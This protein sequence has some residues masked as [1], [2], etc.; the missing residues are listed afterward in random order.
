MNKEPEF[1]IGWQ[2]MAPAAT[3]RLIKWFCLGLFILAASMGTLLALSQ[4][5]IGI[6]V[7]EWGKLK[8]FHGIMV[9]KPYPHLLS[10]NNLQFYYLVKPDK[11]GFDSDIASKYDGQQVCLLGTLIYR[12]NQMMIEALPESINSCSTA[13]DADLLASI[14]PQ[15]DVSLGRQTIIGEI[16][17]SKCFLGVM[18]PGRYVAHKACAIRCISGGCPP[19]F[20]SGSGDA[21]HYYL[22]VNTNGNAVNQAVLDKVAEPLE[23]SGEVV[24]QGA[25]IILKADPTTYKRIK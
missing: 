14:K 10:T 5:T 2:S 20:I 16:V 4:R 12:G 21:L 25:L 24:K 9:A 7:F 13:L 3:G 15:P 23:I 1:Y 19:L 18:N 6:S 8:D 11:F 22:L 17:D